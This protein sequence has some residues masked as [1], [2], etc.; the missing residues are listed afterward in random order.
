MFSFQYFVIM[1]KNLVLTLGL[2][3][4]WQAASVTAVRGDAEKVRRSSLVGFLTS[5]VC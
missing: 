2:L 3:L 1:K 4:L 5:G